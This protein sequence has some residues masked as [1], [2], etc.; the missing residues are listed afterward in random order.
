MN[1]LVF[2]EIAHEIKGLHNGAL[3]KIREERYAEAEEL[4]RKCLTITERISFHE[5]SAVT[6]FSMANLATLQD[7]L[8]TAIQVAERARTRFEL[9]GIYAGDCD[10]LLNRL[11]NS[12]KKRGI[13]LERQGEFSAAIAH[14][15]A[16]IPHSAE[17]IAK[18]LRHEAALLR[19]IINERERT[20]CHR[21]ATA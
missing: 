19:R 17:T 10:A 5:G 2:M 13:E 3:G 16:A 11:A 18:P 4:Y 15:E 8:P 1:D 21:P 20:D 6:L 9:A 12:A 14:F 7:D